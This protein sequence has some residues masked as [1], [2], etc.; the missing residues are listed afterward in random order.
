V[1]QQTKSSSKD[2]TEQI[3]SFCSH[4]A[5]SCQI[6]AVYIFGDYALGLRDT[7]VIE[8]LL[9]LRG[10]Q[11]RLIS[12][13]KTFGN[14][15][16]VVFAVDKWVFERDVD[17]GF[18]GEALSWGLLLPY[19]PIKN[20]E[21]LYQQEV[22]L[23]KRLICELLENLALDFPE[24]SLGF[25]IEPAY[26]M[27]E[28][29]LSR[30]R[31]FPPVVYDVGN[32]AR[33]KGESEGFQQV[34][35]G[36]ME[37]LKELEKEKII[38]I[39]DGYVRI[40]KEFANKSKSR[41]SR[42]V[43]LFKPTQKALFTS[44]LSAFPKILNLISQNAEALFKLKWNNKANTQMLHL[45]PDSK[46]FLYVPTAHGLVPWSNRVNIEDFARSFLT[47]NKNA[48]IEV[49]EIGGVLNE[50]YLVKSL[51]GKEE[52]KVVV[53]RF[54]DWSSFK[55]FP[56]SLWA[57][58]TKTFAV[59]GH[60]RLERE[61]A[62]NHLLFSK[63]FAVPK[64]LHINQSERLVFMEY[65]EGETLEK[66][67]RKMVNSKDV[68]EAKN[69]LSVICKVGEVFA[70]VHAFGISLGDTKPENI[71]IKKDGEICLL[72]F[73]QASRD[74]DK[75]WDVAEFLY[76][77][78]HYI[79]PRSSFAGNKYAQLIAENF[80]KGYLSK[81]RDVNIIKKAGY[82]KYTKVFSVFALPSVMLTMA[83]ICRKADKIKWSN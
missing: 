16:V 19:L 82:P 68:N 55:W 2:L 45:I 37:A 59:T 25:H 49:V 50:A 1:T 12:Y 29:L 76:Y 22:I 38:K 3:C 9:V 46:R 78:G 15:S 48:K 83:G 56:L 70:E 67:I 10:F 41:K 62:I 52:N 32:F 71:I 11:P 34:L 8:V 26:F 21:Y 60:S 65:V 54:R 5:G 44:L 77:A 47:C 23:K 33:I 74:G 79:S 7:K 24:L 51:V 42:F 14:I 53:K 18:L 73:E 81:G 36:Y 39:S 31:L 6:T 69:E 58:G 80:I 66:R 57:V 13:V 72:D 75:T 64:L 61:C 20:E 63:G 43:N 30:T 4:I 17:R 27:Y 40:S 28:A 35:H